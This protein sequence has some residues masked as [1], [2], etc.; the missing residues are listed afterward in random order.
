M[1]KSMPHGSQRYYLALFVVLCE[2]ALVS[3]GLYHFNQ[4]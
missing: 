2:P 3:H 4:G 1:P